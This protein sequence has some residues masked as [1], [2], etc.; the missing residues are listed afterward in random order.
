MNY[1]IDAILI[2]FNVISTAIKPKKEKN[3]VLEAI[4]D[5][6]IQLLLKDYKILNIMLIIMNIIFIVLKVIFEV[7]FI[8]IN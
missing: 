1:V 8:E 3:D 5:H 4:K 6:N 2:A 7:N